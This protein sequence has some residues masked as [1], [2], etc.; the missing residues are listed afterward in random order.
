[1][2]SLLDLRKFI[3]LKNYT[4]QKSCTVRIHQQNSNNH[5][6]YNNRQD[7]IDTINN[8]GR[9]ER[10]QITT[11][12]AVPRW[13][14]IHIK[15]DLNARPQIPQS[16][17]GLRA[18]STTDLKGLILWLLNRLFVTEDSIGYL[19]AWTAFVSQPSF[20]ENRGKT[21]SFPNS[22]FHKTH[23]FFLSRKLAYRQQIRYTYIVSTLL[24]GP[25]I[26][27][28][29]V[30]FLVFRHQPVRLSSFAFACVCWNDRVKFPELLD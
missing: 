13:E 10:S 3:Q 14:L 1:M 9:M 27:P 19:R 24:C 11:H 7:L 20:P 26:T 22:C 29:T 15:C 30:P 28:S 18:H 23:V 5:S 8:Y 6:C 17:L 16:K 21:R 4:K 12:K 25:S 2:H